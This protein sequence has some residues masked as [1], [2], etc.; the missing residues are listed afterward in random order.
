MTRATR[1]E[2]ELNVDSKQLLKP[3]IPHIH[4][5]LLD[6]LGKQLITWLPLAHANTTSIPE[7]GL[8]YVILVS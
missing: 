8:K 5:V 4:K 1:G 7:V 3:G 2:V 6:S